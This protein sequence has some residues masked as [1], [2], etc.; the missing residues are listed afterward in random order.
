ME[1]SFRHSLAH[2]A[3]TFALLA[4]AFLA[5]SCGKDKDFMIDEET[6]RPT[7]GNGGREESAE[8]RNV[9]IFY[10]AGFNNLANYLYDDIN[11]EL[12]SG[13]LPQ[14]HRNDN[15][16]LVYSKLAMN[17]N[18]GN[19]SF[20][21][22]APKKSFLTRIYWD[23]MT[24]KVMKDTVQVF[25]ESHV[26]ASPE[27]LKEVLSIAKSRFPARGYGLL[28]SSHG[29]GWL[30]QDYYYDPSAFERKHAGEL[31]SPASDG[32]KRLQADIPSTR[33]EDDPFFG[34]T[35]SLGRDENSS[36]RS[37]LSKEMTTTEMASGIPFHLD[38]ILFDMCFSASVEA[39]YALKDKA[40]FIGAS[41]AEVLANG[42]FDYSRITSHLLKGKEP[43]IEGLM[44]DGF[45]LYDSFS[46]GVGR[47][48]TVSL[49][50]TDGLDRLASVC[51]LLFE[52]Y[53]SS[54]SSLDYQKVQ[55][56]YRLNRH[57]YFDLEDVFVKCGVSDEDLAV[58]RE[59]LRGCVIFSAST[60]WFL[61]S[62]RISTTCGLST[63]LPKAGTRLLDKYYMEEPWNKETRLVR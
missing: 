57:Y 31:R 14:K 13:W 9:L 4:L 44:K 45:G 34:M 21:D 59:A 11:N 41:C 25:D 36:D 15:V 12:V 58:F 29:S 5:S 19:P 26:A 32:L 27:T 50:R 54:L 40:S 62:F 46:D 24:E 47:S 7:G 61:D 6:A 22:Y 17:M 30:P 60:P 20:E 37:T 10:E 52:R 63:Y 2:A 53:S 1:A 43:D 38:Y 39:I 33:L 23:N 28:F 49:I 42:M 16:V 48:S 18:D 8:T 35:R 55:G 56:Y 51:G 3:A